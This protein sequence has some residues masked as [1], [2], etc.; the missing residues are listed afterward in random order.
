MLDSQQK[1]KIRSVLYHRATLVILALLV[2]IVL[3]STWTV[4]KKKRISEEMKVVSLQNVETLRLRN[5]EILSRIE[6]LKTEVGIEEEIRSKFTVAKNGEN[7][8]VIVEE[9]KGGVATTS[10]SKSLW[11][12]IKS[13][14]LE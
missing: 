6:R 8:V 5:S 2:I 14:F 12:R 4:Y 13:F 11:Q 3:H 1:R 10:Q 7:M 9:E